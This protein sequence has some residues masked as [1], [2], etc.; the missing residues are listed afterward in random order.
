MKPHT[1][2][3]VVTEFSK[4]TD[5]GKYFTTPATDVDKILKKVNFT[6]EVLIEKNSAKAL[7]KAKKLASENHPLVATGSLYLIGEIRD[8]FFP[9]VK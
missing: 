1:K 4:I 9:I 7:E 5:M 2:T 3:F 8:I 6:G